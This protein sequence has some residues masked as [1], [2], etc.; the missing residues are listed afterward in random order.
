MLFMSV[1]SF[2]PAHRDQAMARF[3][4]S[5]GAP[6]AGVTLVGRWHDVGSNRGYTLADTTDPEALF[7]WAMD[8]SDLISFDIHPVLD[9]AGFAKVLGG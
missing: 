5:H 3:K 2:S 4:Q 6:P 8:W 7:K 9:D 1:Y